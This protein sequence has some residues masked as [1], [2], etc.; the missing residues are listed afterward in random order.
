MQEDHSYRLEYDL[1][2]VTG[3]YDFSNPRVILTGIDTLNG[4]TLA[5]ARATLALKLQKTDDL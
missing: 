5:E 4:M 1:D 2:E 3:N